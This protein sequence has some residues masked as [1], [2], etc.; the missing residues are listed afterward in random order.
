MKVA[1][2]NTIG[3]SSPSVEQ[4]RVVIRQEIE[5]AMGHGGDRLTSP[6]ALPKPY[7][8]IKEA[9]DMARLAPSTI[10]LFIRKRVLKA[11]KVGSRVIIK[12]IDHEGFL[13]SH[14]IE[15]LSD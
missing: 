7:L 8:T 6:Q 1:S 13:E 3:D 2:N 10:R 12:R 14:P 4:L 11:N 9:A 15:I 5:A